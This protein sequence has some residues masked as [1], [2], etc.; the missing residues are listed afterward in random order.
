[1]AKWISTAAVAKQLGVGTTSVKRW[2]EQGLLVCRYTPGGHRRFDQE[3]VMAFMRSHS[4]LK[5]SISSNVET[6]LEI[7]TGPTSQHAAY[8]AILRAR[9]RLPSWCALADELGDVLVAVGQ[10]WRSGDLSIS[11]EH[12]MTELLGRALAQCA[13]TIPGNPDKRCVLATAPN[14]PHTLGLSLL[15][16]CIRE[17]GYGTRWLGA[18]TPVEE[19]IHSASDPT[20]TMI[21]LSASGESRDEAKLEHFLAQLKDSVEEN[22]VVVL[23]GGHGR[24]PVDAPVGRRLITFSELPGTLRQVLSIVK[25]R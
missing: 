8:D 12:E 24:W 6:W 3:Q 11:T 7:F 16:V 14:D 17:M 23:L 10:M 15:E 4:A 1:M 20:T 2:A 19:L 18:R 25:D 9:S 5:N 21:A 22:N 13:S